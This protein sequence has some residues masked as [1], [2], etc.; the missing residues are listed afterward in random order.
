MISTSESSRGRQGP[1][2]RTGHIQ[3]SDWY[4]RKQVSFSG[5]QWCLYTIGSGDAR[6][7]GRLTSMQ[8]AWFTG[9][10]QHLKLLV[11]CLL[12]NDR[13]E[14]WRCWSIAFLFMC[15]PI[16]SDRHGKMSGDWICVSTSNKSEKGLRGF[17]NNNTYWP[18]AVGAHTSSTARYQLHCTC[19]VC[20]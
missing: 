11:F 17:T 3:F 13:I 15:P 14:R 19:V 2:F 16:S 12:S 4:L 1:V 8:K 9:G 5:P 20:R 6:L 18:S 10:I 7:A